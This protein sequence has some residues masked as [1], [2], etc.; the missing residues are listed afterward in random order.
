MK[1]LVLIFA[2][3]VTNFVNAQTTK[4]KLTDFPMSWN[5]GDSINDSIKRIL[6]EDEIIKQLN[7]YRASIGMKA[8]VKDT[9]LSAAALHNAVYNRWCFANKILQSENTTCFMTH[10]QY[11]DMPGFE[12][13][14][15]P[16]WR[17]KL[18]DQTKFKRITEELTYDLSA[19]GFLEKQTM[20]QRSTQ[21]IT[22]F[23][24]SDTHWHNMASDAVWDC[25]YVLYDLNTWEVNKGTGAVVYVILGEY[26]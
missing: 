1:K 13:I 18:L 4:I 5:V 6:I 14:N 9:G 2:I 25:V 10:I 26:N 21:V 23:K 20:Q 22:Q 8:L 15:A 16:S 24:A 17:I 19:I 7:T 11:K 3:A 12:E